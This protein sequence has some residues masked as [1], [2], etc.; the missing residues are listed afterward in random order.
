MAKPRVRG[1]QGQGSIHLRVD[2]RWEARLSLGWARGKRIVKSFFGQ[3]REEVEKKLEHGKSRLARGLA[4]ARE[5][6]RRR[7]RYAKLPEVAGVLTVVTALDDEVHQPILDGV[8]IGL[9]PPQAAMLAGVSL[10]TF[11]DWCE[12][13]RAEVEP[14]AALSH[15]IA[16]TEVEHEARLLQIVNEAGIVDPKIA[17]KLLELR[18]PTRWSEPAS[19]AALG[20]FDSI[21]VVGLHVVINLVEAPQDADTALRN[22]KLLNL[23]VRDDE[24]PN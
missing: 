11:N 13:G 22:A 20:G 5:K 6:P 17:L 23:A 18:C 7:P 9:H 1:E 10:K 12:Q 15:A 4:V 14:Y 2:G 3:S 19:R 8:A 24:V 21:N 16:A